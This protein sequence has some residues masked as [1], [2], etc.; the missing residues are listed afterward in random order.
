[1]NAVANPCGVIAATIFN[2][3]YNLTNNASPINILSTGI[4][5]PSDIIKFKNSNASQMWYDVS[6]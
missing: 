3:T 1:M 5:W 4:A 2:D 6:D